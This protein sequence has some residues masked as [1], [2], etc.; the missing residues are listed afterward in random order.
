MA[1]FAPGAR[2]NQDNCRPSHTIRYNITKYTH[3]TIVQLWGSYDRYDPQNAK[4]SQGILRRT[5]A[6]IWIHV[7]TMDAFKL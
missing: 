5:V 7:T 1:I 4:D 6:Q 2:R 3:G